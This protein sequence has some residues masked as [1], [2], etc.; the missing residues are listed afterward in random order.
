MIEFIE[1]DNVYFT[2]EDDIGDIW[3]MD[4]VAE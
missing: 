4:V 1:G 3:V 2:W